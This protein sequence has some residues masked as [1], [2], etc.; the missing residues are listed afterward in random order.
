[1]EDTNSVSFDQQQEGQP[2]TTSAPQVQE[3]VVSNNGEVNQSDVLKDAVANAIK[4]ILPT[5][6]QSSVQQELRNFQSM[7]DKMQARIKKETQAAIDTL[8]NAGVE[9]TPKVQEAIATQTKQK[10]TSELSDSNS[11]PQSAQVDG[12]DTANVDASNVNQIAEDYLKKNNLPVIATND[13]EAGIIIT[14]G[15]PEEY[16]RTYQAAAKA[17]SLRLSQGQ[18]ATKAPPPSQPITTSGG[19]RGNPISTINDMDSLYEMAIKRR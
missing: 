11:Q 6:V 3:P 10:I 17:K 1:M 7:A 4:E 13:P 12:R 9:I 16:L 2:A 19:A 15:T 18:T 14:N 8:K 5:V